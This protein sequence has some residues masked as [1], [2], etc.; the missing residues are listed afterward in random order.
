VTTAAGVPREAAEAAEAAAAEE[1]GN[2]K[3][4]KQ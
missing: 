1:K 4:L 3:S 2:L